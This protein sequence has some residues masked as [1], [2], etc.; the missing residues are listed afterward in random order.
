MSIPVI[1]VGQAQEAVVGGLER[2]H[3]PVTVVRR[4]SELAELMAACQS[5]L[6]L[7]AVVAEGCEELTATLVDRLAAVGVS[8]LALTVDP[9]EISRLTAIGVVTAS[10]D[11]EPA[12]LA[13]RISDAVGRHGGP[14]RARK[15]PDAGFAD[16][17]AGFQLAAEPRET[18][19]AGSGRVIA[20][21]GPT[22][23]PGRTLV[24]VNM[25]A[26][27]AA[28]GKSVILVDADSYGASVSA[29]LG[30]LEESAGLAQGL[31]AR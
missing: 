24:A 22:G 15:F 17:S 19:A 5:G 23:A 9:V 3:G 25:A 27:L 18:E 31:Q 13:V 12:A 7:A 29:M 4:C 10:T 14:L 2:L 1:T 26:E 16:S 20:V 28:E 8:I 6:A 30:L 21:W 11:I